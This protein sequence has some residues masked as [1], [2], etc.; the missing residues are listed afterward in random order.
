MFGKT[1]CRN[2][3]NGP[4]WCGAGFF[5]DLLSILVRDR[6]T[7]RNCLRMLKARGYD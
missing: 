3:P 6:I 2:G 5:V 4:A 1:H 7:C